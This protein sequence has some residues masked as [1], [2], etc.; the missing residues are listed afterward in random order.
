MTGRPVRLVPAAVIGIGLVLVGCSGSS[1]GGD[2]A[3][4]SATPASA[5]AWKPIDRGL[6]A[7]AP[8]VGFLA[9]RVSKDGRCEPRHAIAPSTARP[10][11]SQFKL[12]V[13][14][15]LAR[16]IASG[17]VGWDQRLTIPE[18]V[19]SLGNSPESGGLA[20]APPGSSF[21]V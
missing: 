13:L 6:A 21:T 16:Q 14:G 12:F 4:S 18:S 20:F 3:P 19:K 10:T 1:A 17:K 9:A 5:R 8:E 11:A 15:A 2:A 7:L